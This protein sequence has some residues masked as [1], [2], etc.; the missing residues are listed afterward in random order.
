MTFSKMGKMKRGFNWEARVN[1]KVV[2]D[3]SATKDVS[4]NTAELLQNI[5]LL[6]N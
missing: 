1:K 6:V 2:I 4:T 3:D 5:R